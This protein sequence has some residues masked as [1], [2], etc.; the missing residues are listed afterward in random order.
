[1]EFEKVRPQ[2]EDFWKLSDI[3]LTLDHAA[4]TDPD[5]LYRMIAGAVDSY[6]VIYMSVQRSMRAV[7]ADTPLKLAE[8]QE[9]VNTTAGA[10]L[11][12]FFVGLQFY[13]E[14]K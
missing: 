11:D 8:K 3:I 10:W 9:E 13:K 7:G 6:S 14:S 12:G 5:A 4:E 1:M 2:H